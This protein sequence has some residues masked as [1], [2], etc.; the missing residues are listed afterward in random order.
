M[1]SKY[2]LPIVAL[3]GL[4]FAL[5]YVFTSNKPAQIAAPVA[6]PAQASFKKYIAGSGLIEA[7][8]DNISIATPL[9]GV[10][11]KIAV[12][13]GSRVK[14]GAVLFTLEGR[15][16][17]A[18]LPIRR[19]AV[20]EAQANLRDAQDQLQRMAQIPDQRAVSAEEL[21]RRRIAVNLAEARLDSAQGQLQAVKVHLD[22]LVIRAPI[23]GE[24]LQLNVRNG[25]YAQAGV[26]AMP[27]LLLGN[28]DRLHVRVDIDENDAWRFNPVA[29]AQAFLRGA[30]NAKANLK[31][32]RVEPFV[33]PKT[34]LTGDSTERVDTR[35]LQV[36][37]SFDRAQLAAYVG[38]QM[39]VFIE[40]VSAAQT[41]PA[42]SSVA[43]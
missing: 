3:L 34:S 12:T 35:V 23:N 21:D 14:K 27:L 4:L 32:V 38:Q 26:L 30:P 6:E 28:L 37:Y 25:E 9:S 16:V 15:D 22:R 33:V 1:L 43:P 8:S 2:K 39:D 5:F 20:A 18:D 42:A 31:L 29:P 10:V 19:A 11:N 24:V 7:Q 36:V 13:V 41:Q 17:Q 40:D